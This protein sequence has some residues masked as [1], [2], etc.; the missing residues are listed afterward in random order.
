MK[1]G[2]SLSKENTDCGCMRIKALMNTYEHN[3]DE[4]TGEWRKSLTEK[5][6]NLYR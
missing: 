3:K 6:H 1:L 4:E 2:L 5:L